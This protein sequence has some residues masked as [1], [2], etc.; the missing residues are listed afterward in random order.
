MLD[1]N[2]DQIDNTET[3]TSATPTAAVP[4]PAAQPAAPA[5]VQGGSVFSRL[6]GAFAANGI[7]IPVEATVGCTIISGAMKFGSDMQHDFGDWVVIRPM[8]L[9]V[10]E[11]VNLGIKGTASPEEKKLMETCKDGQTVTHD[12]V[13]YTKAEYLAF[14]KTQ[15]YSNAKFENRAVLHGV[16]IDSD[17]DGKIGKELKDDDIIAVWLSPSSLKAW[18]AFVVKSSLTNT[19]GAL[20][21]LKLTKVERRNA[22]SGVNWTQFGFEAVPQVERQVA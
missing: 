17:R 2:I 16:Y 13:T 22:T 21:D 19:R 3:T 1:R 7:D 9:T 11:K 5:L 20:S 10:Y 8:N 4:A 14:L 15:G 18:N 12:E 6:L